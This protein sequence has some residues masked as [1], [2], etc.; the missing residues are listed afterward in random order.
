RSPSSIGEL[1]HRSPLIVCCRN[2]YM[3]VWWCNDRSTSVLA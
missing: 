2:N 3:E 1:M